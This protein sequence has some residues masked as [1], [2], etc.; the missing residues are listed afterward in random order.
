MFWTN[1]N[2]GQR[3]LGDLHIEEKQTYS[4]AEREFNVVRLDGV[5]LGSSHTEEEDQ[6]KESPPAHETGEMTVAKQHL[7]TPQH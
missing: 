5:H 3:D 6:R 7:S 4:S 2:Q 1:Q